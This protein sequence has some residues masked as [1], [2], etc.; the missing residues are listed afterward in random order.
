MNNGREGAF[1]MVGLLVGCKLIVGGELEEGELVGLRL[2]VVVG[3]WD[4]VGLSEGDTL[5]R[6]VGKSV[7]AKLGSVVGLLEG[8]NEGR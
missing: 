5:G 8:I 6:T 2:G 1:D 7:G 3:I 4:I